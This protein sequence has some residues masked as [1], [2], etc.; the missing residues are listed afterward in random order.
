MLLVEHFAD[1][2][3]SLSTLCFLL[4]IL[5]RFTETMCA[6]KG[7]LNIASSVQIKFLDAAKYGVSFQG[8]S[9]C[10]SE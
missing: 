6:I 7:A 10:A 4:N 3:R 2:D 8:M 9:I 5:Q 1:Y